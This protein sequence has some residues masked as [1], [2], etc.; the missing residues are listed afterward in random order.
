MKKIDCPDGP[1]YFL[2]NPEKA[3]SIHFSEWD[4]RM[5]Q[6]LNVLSRVSFSGNQNI[7]VRTGTIVKDLTERYAA[8][9][10]HYQAA[11]LGWYGNPCS[12]DAEHRYHEAKDL[13]CAKELEL[14]KI[15]KTIG[16]TGTRNR[17]MFRKIKPHNNG[18][19]RKYPRKKTRE[20]EEQEFKESLD[21]EASYSLEDGFVKERIDKIQELVSRLKI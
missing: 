5:S 18:V 17:F 14:T 8:L 15:E 20:P 19:D 2:A 13:I 10:S 3:F 6:L 4:I 11:Y 21:K 7:S 1:R 16:L 9:Q 12:K